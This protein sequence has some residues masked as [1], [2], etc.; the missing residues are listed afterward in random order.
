MGVVA[1]RVTTP[2]SP[3]AV[4]SQVAGVLAVLAILMFPG[5]GSQQ[6]ANSQDNGIAQLHR[7]LSF[8]NPWRNKE[9]GS[10]SGTADLRGAENSPQGSAEIPGRSTS[11]IGSARKRAR[12]REH[13]T[14]MPSSGKRRRL[15][16]PALSYKGSY[17]M[18]SDSSSDESGHDEGKTARK[19]VAALMEVT[20]RQ[21][22]WTFSI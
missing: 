3:P 4:G 17:K 15:G 1:T 10:D 21:D 20:L 22:D 12:V 14:L 6:S 9:D 16:A 8:L 19:P 18:D 11:P 2:R 5:S 13:R 7:R